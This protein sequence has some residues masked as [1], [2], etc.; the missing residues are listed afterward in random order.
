MIAYYEKCGIRFAYPENWTIA[1]EQLDES[2]QGVS[3]HSPEGGYWDLAN[4]ATL[5]S[6]DIWAQIL[7]SVRYHHA[8]IMRRQHSYTNLLTSCTRQLPKHQFGQ[9]GV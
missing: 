9:R 8:S 5:V 2:P 6:L 4:P 7:H 1:D 3:V